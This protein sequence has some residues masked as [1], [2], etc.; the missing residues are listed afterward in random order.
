MNLEQLR[1]VLKTAEA[2]YRSD[3]RHDVADGLAK[4]S[5]NVLNVGDSQTVSA[6]VSRIEKARKPKPSRKSVKGRRKR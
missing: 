2:Q 5:A 3:G 1:A 4:F 6:F